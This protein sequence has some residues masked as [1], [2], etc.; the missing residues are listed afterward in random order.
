MGSV[1]IYVSVC[2]CAS[3]Y[4]W[5]KEKS[6]QSG[7]LLGHNWRRTLI[8]GLLHDSTEFK[9]R[10]WTKKS[11]SLNSCRAPQRNQSNSR[12]TNLAAVNLLQIQD[13]TSSAHGSKRSGRGWPLHWVS[14]GRWI[15]HLILQPLKE[16][17][18]PTNFG[19]PGDSIYD[20]KLVT[21]M[22]V[23]LLTSAVS[24]QA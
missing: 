22:N 2:V 21:L 5:G 3:T 12:K 9:C 4:E 17:R 15:H 14:P 23:V 18:N 10:S 8:P 20:P 24:T 6:W 7:C 13:T 1:C 11:R 16:H 19:R